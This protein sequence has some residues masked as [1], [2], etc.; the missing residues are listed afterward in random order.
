MNIYLNFFFFSKLYSMALEIC[1]TAW[2]IIYSSSKSVHLSLAAGRIPKPWPRVLPPNSVGCAHH[3][4]PPLPARRRCLLP[5][6]THRWGKQAE[7]NTLGRP[8]NLLKMCSYWHWNHST[9]PNHFTTALWQLTLLLHTYIYI[10]VY[11][12][13]TNWSLGQIFRT[14]I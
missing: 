4:V 11:F 3:L 6:H 7:T 5:L 12:A 8:L 2:N 1:P 9:L 10:N 14:L 13:A